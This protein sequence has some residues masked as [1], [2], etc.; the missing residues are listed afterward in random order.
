MALWGLDQRGPPSVRHA[1]GSLPAARLTMLKAVLNPI[2]W[3]T[4]AHVHAHTLAA[5]PGDAADS[6]GF[7]LPS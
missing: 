7:V 3:H 2:I 5:E 1:H 6:Q 4:T